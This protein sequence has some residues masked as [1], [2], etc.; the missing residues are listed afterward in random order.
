MGPYL[1]GRRRCDSIVQRGTWK[2]QVTQWDQRCGEDP[3]QPRPG[4]VKY[5][6]RLAI[7]EAPQASWA[8]RWNLSHS[9]AGVSSCVLGAGPVGVAG[10]APDSA[11]A[12]WASGCPG[13]A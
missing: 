8:Q 12:R 13:W 4:A 7:E 10:L 9:Q 2:P 6:A 5:G 3:R 11:C 1:C